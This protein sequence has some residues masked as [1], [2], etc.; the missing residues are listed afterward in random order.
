MRK[1]HMGYEITCVNISGSGTMT[2]PLR[3]FMR[4]QGL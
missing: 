2:L 3:K 1:S 4:L